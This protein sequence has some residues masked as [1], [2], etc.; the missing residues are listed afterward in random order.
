MTL[1]AMLGSYIGPVISSEKFEIWKA[2]K[3]DSW[4]YI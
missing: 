4:C 2:N 1:S 3:L